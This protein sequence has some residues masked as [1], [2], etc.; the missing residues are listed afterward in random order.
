MYVQKFR[1]LTVWQRSIKFVTFI[2]ELTSKFPKEERFG[3]VDQI[4]RAA[5]SIALN[6]AEGSGAGSDA[7]FIRFLKMAQRSA[8]EVLAA[9]E[10]AINLK[11]TSLTDLQNASLEVDELSAMIGGLIKKL[12]A[13]S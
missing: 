1:K 11:M 7:E 2:Y 9:L 5:V 8:Y 12:K 4:R 13:V 10:I 3:L 6:I